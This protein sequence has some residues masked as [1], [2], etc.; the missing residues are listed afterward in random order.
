M[1]EVLVGLDKRSALAAME[2]LKQVISGVNEGN[3]FADL[4]C[5]DVDNIKSDI[6]ANFLIIDHNKKDNDV[7]YRDSNCEGGF[8]DGELAW[9]E[10]GGD[11]YLVS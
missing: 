8:Y 11:V 7:M 1:D 6:K 2:A 9:E 4:D 5:V 3:L 10:A